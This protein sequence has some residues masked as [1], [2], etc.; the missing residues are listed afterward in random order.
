MAYHTGVEGREGQ[1]KDKEHISFRIRNRERERDRGRMNQRGTHFDR[2]ERRNFVPKKEELWT[3][4]ER[5]LLRSSISERLPDYYYGCVC[6]SFSSFLR[7]TGIT[8]NIEKGQREREVIRKNNKNIHPPF[9]VL[10]IPSSIPFSYP[11]RICI[12]VSGVKGERE[13]ERIVMM[14]RW[15]GCFFTLPFHV[16]TKNRRKRKLW[17]WKYSKE[18]KKVWESNGAPSAILTLRHR[19]KPLSLSV[20]PSLSLLSLPGVLSKLRNK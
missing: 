11:Y 5:E 10:S 19:T 15:K 1:R 4:R 12:I 9:K 14:C 3:E 16:E 7:E 20:L 13:R 18:R 17:R 2:I 6:A 8:S